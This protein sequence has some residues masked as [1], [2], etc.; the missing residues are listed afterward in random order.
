MKI[1]GMLGIVATLLL[2]AFIVVQT[3]LADDKALWF[4]M[5]LP[6]VLVG[7][8]LMLQSIRLVRS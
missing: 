4:G 6:L 2:I 3:V 7:G 1:L 5:I 8:P